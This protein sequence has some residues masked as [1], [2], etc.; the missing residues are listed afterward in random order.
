MPVGQLGHGLFS[1]AAALLD[2]LLIHGGFLLNDGYLVNT[3]L[4][5]PGQVRRT[6][7]NA[8]TSMP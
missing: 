8:C 5:V 6:K 3:S 7:Y 2:I 4:I 1:L